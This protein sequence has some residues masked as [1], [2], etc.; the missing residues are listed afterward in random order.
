MSMS[1]ASKSEETDQSEET[2]KKIPNIWVSCPDMPKF[3]GQSIKR[4]SDAWQYMFELK[5]PVMK[6]GQS[7]KT[8]VC[9]VCIWNFMTANPGKDVPWRD[10]LFA[11]GTH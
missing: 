5:T 10:Y 2:D 6:K 3:K 1:M 9:A 4:L 8:H 11:T 7:K